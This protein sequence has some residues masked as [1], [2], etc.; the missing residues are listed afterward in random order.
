MTAT[1]FP[2]K[3]APRGVLS[4]KPVYMRLMP[5]ERHKLEQLSAVQNQSTS[6]VARLVFLEGID[7]YESHVTATVTQ[8]PANLVAEH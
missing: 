6:S 4:D 3:R 2:K 7:Q 5:A 8:A 1:Q